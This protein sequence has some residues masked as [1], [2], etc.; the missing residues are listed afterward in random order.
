MVLSIRSATAVAISHQEIA[1]ITK[2]EV[3]QQKGKVML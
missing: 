3:M 1:I 2:K